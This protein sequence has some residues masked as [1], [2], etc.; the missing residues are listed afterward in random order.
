MKTVYWA[1]FSTVERQQRINFLMNQPSKLI[2]DLFKNVD[3]KQESYSQCPAAQSSL[4]NIYYFKFPFDI[5]LNFNEEGYASGNRADW[6]NQRNKSYTNRINADLDL[7]W[8]FFCE[9]DLIIEQSPTYMHNTEFSKFGMSVTGSFNIS[10][11]FRPIMTSF[12]LWENENN[13][14]A[15]EG[16]PM[17]YVR[18]LTDEKITLQQFEVTQKIKDIA[19][20]CTL[21]S[22]YYKPRLPLMARYKK[23]KDSKMQKI[24]IKE[25]QNNLIG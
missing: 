3:N 5:N 16:E 22:L 4:K 15:K 17:I 13:F 10:S 2:D 12:I 23:F 14:V 9:E 19:D 8:V 25:I 20:A 6:F 24:L 18:F 21:S 11:W 7:G 1:N